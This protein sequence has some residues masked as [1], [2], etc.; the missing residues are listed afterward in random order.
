MFSTADKIIIRPTGIELEA[1]EVCLKYPAWDELHEV[2][3]KK[4][5]NGG[6]FFDKYGEIVDI[7]ED[8]DIVIKHSD[9][10]WSLVKRKDFIKNYEEI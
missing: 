2:I 4:Y 7:I 3:P 1:Y 5:F 8:Y 6:L 10:V 9:G